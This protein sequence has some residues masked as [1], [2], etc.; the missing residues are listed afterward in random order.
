MYSVDIAS[1]LKTATEKIRF[2]RDRIAVRDELRQHIEEKWEDFREQ[3]IPEKEIDQRILKDMGSAKELAPLLAEIHKPYW[4]YTMVIL[5]WVMVAILVITFF[6]AKDEFGRLVARTEDDRFTATENN[7]FSRIYMVEPDTSF[8]C[9]NYK[10]TV[11]KAALWE[12][13]HSVHINGEYFDIEYTLYLEIKM[14]KY[15]FHPSFQ[16]WEYFWAEDD[17]GN[18]YRSENNPPTL[19]ASGYLW[20]VRTD[21]RLFYDIVYIDF[22]GIRDPNLKWIDLHYDADGR[23]VTVRIDLAGGDRP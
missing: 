1:W 10:F 18:I 11:Q 6:A 19:E 9:D 16:G 21:N 13:G 14:M 17:L 22:I 8:T 20:E 3:G 7:H 12:S 5:K 23:D 15:P 2:R 4:G